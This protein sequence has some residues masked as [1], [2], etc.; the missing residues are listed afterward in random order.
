MLSSA[1]LAVLFAAAG[2]CLSA[3]SAAAQ[4][5]LACY[6]LH[7]DLAN[8]DRRARQVDRY[9]PGG[10][11]GRKELYD[12]SHL[13]GSDVIRLRI[14]DEMR[15]FGCPLP[16]EAFVQERQEDQEHD[17]GTYRPKSV[18][19]PVITLPLK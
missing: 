12:R 11:W 6:T 5:V 16:R 13:G 7:N 19:K 18:T 15:R 17:G 8:F 1:R 2:L 4:Q 10:G 9:F 14:I 3:G